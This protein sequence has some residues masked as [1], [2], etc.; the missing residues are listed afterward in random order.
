MKNL[1][2]Q[3]KAEVMEFIKTTLAFD[4]QLAE[5]LRYVK[6]DDFKKEHRRFKM[7]GYESVTGQCTVSN[8]SIVNE[9]AHLGIYDYTSYLFLDFYKGKPTL[10]LKYF[11]EEENLEFDFWSLGTVEIIYE[12]FKL[13]IF[14]GKGTR[15][16]T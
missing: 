9:F 7:S 15:R 1:A 12:I 13:T 8:M 5:Q 6:Q 2:T 4:D 14:S 3:S 10:Y 11:Y 16:R